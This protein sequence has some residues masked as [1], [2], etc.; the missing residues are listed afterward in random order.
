MEKLATFYLLL[1]LV[2]LFEEFILGVLGSL[3][4]LIY[5]KDL[6][7]GLMF[8]ERFLVIMFSFGSLWKRN[9]LKSLFI[10]ELKLGSKLGLS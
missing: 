2:K 4:G 10:T 5:I 8:Y 7:D 6:F 9:F 3:K 1:L